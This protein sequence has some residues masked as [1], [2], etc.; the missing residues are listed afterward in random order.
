MRN[1]KAQNM[2]KY[3]NTNSSSIFSH[4]STS[5]SLSMNV[6]ASLKKK[7]ARI[8]LSN[9]SDLKRKLKHH[10]TKKLIIA[11]Q[12]ITARGIQLKNPFIQDHFCFQHHMPMCRPSESMIGPRRP[13]GTVRLRERPIRISPLSIISQQHTRSMRLANY[14]TFYLP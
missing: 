5:F 10:L 1:Q 13:I 6:V 2:D 9:P 3:L 8:S 11:T 7:R 14:F 4:Y 12:L